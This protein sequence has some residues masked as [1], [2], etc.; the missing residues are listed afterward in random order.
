MHNMQTCRALC[1]QPLLMSPD[2]FTLIFVF[3]HEVFAKILDLAV[4][5]MNSSTNLLRNSCS[6]GT[7]VHVIHKVGPYVSTRGTHFCQ[8]IRYGHKAFL[9]LRWTVLL[10]FVR[11]PVHIFF[12][13]STNNT[14]SCDSVSLNGKTPRPVTAATRDQGVRRKCCPENCLHHAFTIVFEGTRQ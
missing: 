1:P 10:C 9:W 6:R 5:T 13:T 12:A 14:T 11:H 4:I 3:K 7:H 8:Q 2:I